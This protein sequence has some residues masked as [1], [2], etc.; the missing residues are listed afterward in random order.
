[1][2]AAPV[3]KHHLYLL[4]Q[5]GKNIMQSRENLLHHLNTLDHGRRM[6]ARSREIRTRLG[7]LNLDEPLRAATD[8]A[9]LLSERGT[10]AARFA[11]TAEGTKH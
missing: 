11:L 5:G 3:Q 1:M 8:R 4:W 9:D 10:G 6:F 2:M 7:T